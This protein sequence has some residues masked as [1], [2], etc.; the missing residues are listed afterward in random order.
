MERVDRRTVVLQRV[1]SLFAI[2]PRQRRF[3]QELDKANTGAFEL[4]LTPLI[5]AGIGVWLSHI[6]GGG[7]V[8]PFVLGFVALGGTVYRLVTDYSRRMKKASEGKPWAKP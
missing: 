5:F 1:G 7:L 6:F 3:I 8:L 2:G 4:V